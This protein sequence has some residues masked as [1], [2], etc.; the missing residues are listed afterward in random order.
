V[1]VVKNTTAYG[2][3]QSWDVSHHSHAHCLTTVPT[4]PDHAL[5]VHINTAPQYL[6]D[7]VTTV[8]ESSTWPGI[9]SADTAAYT[10]PR[11]I[12]R[13]GERGFCYAG[14]VAWNSLPSHL[15]SITVTIV[16]KHKLKTEPFTPAF[17]HWQFLSA[18]LADYVHRRFKNFLCISICIC[19][20]T[21]KTAYFPGQSV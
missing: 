21:Q 3:I 5:S 11:T 15:L 7:I 10:R 19:N 4:V 6:T 1:A 14:A 13:F 9:W 2:V 20:T 16:L 12:I 17:D 8:G 18:L